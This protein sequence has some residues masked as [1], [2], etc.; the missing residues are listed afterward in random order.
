MPDLRGALFR[1]TAAGAFELRD[2]DAILLRVVE[3]VQAEC[4]RL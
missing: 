2:A 4:A 1:A 3:H